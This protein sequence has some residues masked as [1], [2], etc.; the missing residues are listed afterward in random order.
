MGLTGIDWMPENNYCESPRQTY[1]V[2]GGMQIVNANDK[3]D[4]PTGLSMADALTLIGEAVA[5]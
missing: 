3:V 2:K 4:I 1:G 5:V